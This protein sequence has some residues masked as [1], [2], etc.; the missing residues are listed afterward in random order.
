MKKIR[1][2]ISILISILLL[3]SLIQIPVKAASV[4]SWVSC[5]RSLYLNGSSSSPVYGYRSPTATTVTDTAWDR[6]SRAVTVTSYRY[7]KLSDGS[8]RYEVVGYNSNEG[9]DVTLY[10]K[11]SDVSSV[12]K[13]HTY[14]TAGFADAHPHKSIQTCA[15]GDTYYGTSTTTKTNCSSCYPLGTF[16]PSQSY[17]SKEGNIKFT[18]GSVTNKSYVSINLY[19]DGSKYSTY[20]SYGTEYSLNQL[21]PGSYYAQLTVCNS[22]TGQ[23]KSS[24][25]STVNLQSVYTIN[26]D[27]NEG[28]NAPVNQQKEY[29][30]D[31]QLSERQPTRE[32]YEF[33]GWA[34]SASS[35]NVMYNPGD[36]YNGNSSLTLYA[37]WALAEGKCG[38]SVEWS[39]NNGKLSITGN[40]DMYNY[41]NSNY[42]ELSRSPWYQ[43][44]D[45][46]SEVTVQNG[47]T[48]ISS[49]GFFNLSVIQD[50]TIPK[51]VVSIGESAFKGCSNLE[52]INVDSDNSFLSVQ[53][54]VIFNKDKTILITYAAKDDKYIVPESVKKIETGAFWNIDTLKT[55][56]FPNNLQ[57]IGVTAFYGCDA[58][59]N[60]T[61]PNS[62][63]SIG[64]Y[65]FYSNNSLKSLTV[66][67]SVEQIGNYNFGCPIYGINNSYVHNYATTNNKT[68]NMTQ[69]VEA[70]S[71]SYTS[72]GTNKIEISMESV[73]DGAQIYYTLDGSDPYG[74]KNLYSEPI[75]IEKDTNIRAIAVKSQML[76]SEIVEKTYS[77][78]AVMYLTFDESSGTITGCKQNA[79]NITVP[80]YI[81]GVKVV[82]LGDRA[83]ENCANLYTINLPESITTIGQECF[84]GCE[85]LQS[86]TLPNNVTSIGTGV[87]TDCSSLGTATLSNSLTFIPN[88]TF[89]N[90]QSLNNVKINSS[91]QSIGLEAF[92][93][94]EGLTNLSIPRSVTNIGNNAF[95]GCSS[96]RNVNIPTGV[97]SIGVNTFK[98]CSALVKATIPAEVTSIA[99]GAF[100][101]CSRLVIYGYNNSTAQTYANE[102]NIDFVLIP[103]AVSSINETFANDSL[104]AGWTSDS[105]SGAYWSVGSTQEGDY[106]AMFNSY[107]SPSG[108]KGRLVSPSVKVAGGQTVFVSYYMRHDLG[109]STRKDKLHLEYSVDNGDT[110]IPL[111]DDKIRYDGTEEWEKITAEIPDLENG[112][113][114]IGLL[115]TSDYGNYIYVDNITVSPV[116]NTAEVESVSFDVS[117]I[118]MNVG[119]ERTIK[120]SILPENARDRSLT[121]TS[122]NNSVV[123]VDDGHITA[124]ADGTATITATSS[125]G[126]KATCAIT[127][128]KVKTLPEVQTNEA[129]NITTNSASVS[130]TV[131]SDGNSDI[132]KRQITYYEKNSPDAKYT[133][134]ADSSF[135]AALTNLK[136]STEYWYQAQAEN[137]IGAAV[138]EIKS[139]RTK[140]EEIIIEPDSITISPTYL[141]LNPNDKRTLSVTVL[142][143][144][145]ENRDVVW[146]SENPSVVTVD[147]DGNIT[148]VGT[149]T[150]R[151]KATTVVNRLEAYCEIEVK[152]KEVAG[153]FDFSEH[154]MITSSSN[155][156]ERNGFDFGPDD[157]GN[158]TMST[159]YL[160]RWDG[161]V[162]EENDAYPSPAYPE[163]IK[164]NQVPSDYH[165]Q[166]VLYLPSRESYTDNNDIKKAIMDYGAVYASFVVD[167]SCFDNSA[168]NYY[169]PED[170]YAIRGHAIAIVGW[171]DNYS[172]N[173]FTNTPPADGAF[174]CKNSWGKYSGDDGYFYISYYDANIGSI[175]INTVFNNIE[176]NTNYNKIYQYDPLGA[177]GGR[178]YGNK[179]YGANVFPAED[180]K[181]SSD[182]T[183]KAVSF[184]TND[185]GTEY[186]V[187]VVTNYQSVNSLKKLGSSVASGVMEYAGYHTVNLPEDITIKAGTRFAVVV[188]LSNSSGA[189]MSVETPVRGYSSKARANSG[190]SFMSA[191]GSSWTDAT[192][193]A[194]NTN[195]CIKAFTQTA[196]NKITLMSAIDN[197]EREYETDTAYSVEET[198]DNGFEIN[199]ELVDYLNNR[200]DNDIS[201]FSVEQ[202]EVSMGQIPD[203]IVIGNTDINFTEGTSFP[204]RYDLRESNGVTPVKNQGQ[205]GSCWSFATYASLESC[206]LKKSDNSTSSLISIDNIISNSA[207]APKVE[208]ISIPTSCNMAVNTNKILQATVTPASVSSRGIKWSSSN[209]NV[210]TVDT[211]GRIYAKS[212]G[213]AKITAELNGVKD[214]CTINVTSGTNVNGISL[215]SKNRL[216]NIGDKLILAYTITPEDA[217]NQSVVWLSSDNS[218]AAVDEYGVIAALSEGTAD[219]TVQTADGNK[220]DICTLTVGNAEIVKYEKVFEIQ[221]EGITNGMFTANI[222]NTSDSKQSGTAIFA[223]YDDEGTLISVYSEDMKDVLSASSY[224]FATD[225]PQGSSKYKVMVWNSYKIMAPIADSKNID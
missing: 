181:L 167:R 17:D 225:V 51:S 210:A 103:D 53:D 96:L 206:I 204:S 24:T 121:W 148:A 86:I 14:Y 187:Y 39:Y 200:H 168:T 164:Y 46:I 50:F 95:N 41:S 22:N 193:M 99:S 87:F 34:T 127:V 211:S 223:A 199:P 89:K 28:V 29:G 49:F 1:K 60:I 111:T 64:E 5:K 220:T 195:V 20:T 71:M 130:G 16:S 180:S 26:Y 124:L 162:L 219:I 133:V 62:V 146:E 40:G 15:C 75:I 21:P 43:L 178:S 136:P 36:T 128:S 91:I 216:C 205:I 94:C 67:E 4:S 110:W 169:L 190:E 140:D 58:L 56:I 6:Y 197:D 101:N 155:M 189:Y 165:V 154:N 135:N 171:D 81:N 160:T 179:V 221:D 212:V 72:Y 69:Y 209:E 125:N 152:K 77:F 85:S 42:S 159:A 33:M 131:T 2:S 105:N 108:S 215:N 208:D 73:T 151:I 150:T 142:P 186:E 84:K 139:L 68:F 213:S 45:E 116:D 3:C 177:I 218:V 25:L 153:T 9:R 161:A 12:T 134:D 7:A 31:I 192:S 109:Y 132:T 79:T 97:T 38:D 170:I 222:A 78:D 27:A 126:K 166:E 224:F 144:N 88:R 158:S 203:A 90:C 157:G 37:V 175:G 30:I 47:I 176:S 35:T 8:I 63:K 183:L 188:K 191:N 80:E 92:A 52:N 129:E 123:S 102:N 13:Q 185:K 120:S 117:E 66:P 93:G 122:S 147:N 201:L 184:Y 10:F 104:P 182:E 74:A 217:A 172:K 119:D 138:G 83:F 32:G 59:E 48:H 76:N 145:A 19:K 57:E 107:S 23:T 113:V 98:D 202:N 115:G 44:R 100:A 156:N 174:I 149:G 196:Q 55:I 198:I 61:L 143:E 82:S 194:A 112:T 137:E 214:E 114:C 207:S 70:P 173:N 65:A 54:N 118:N 11:A 141:S 163:N 106:H 18:W